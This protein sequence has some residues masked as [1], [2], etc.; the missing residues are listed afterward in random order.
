MP[1]TS[2]PRCSSIT[3]SPRHELHLE[4]AFDD[5][6]LARRELNGSGEGSPHVLRSFGN[7]K[8]R[9]ALAGQTT[10]RALDLLPFK[11]A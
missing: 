6:E 11:R 9:A 10:S 5:G 1:D 4:R 8:L 2:R 7:A 3:R